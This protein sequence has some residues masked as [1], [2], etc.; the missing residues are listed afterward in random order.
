MVW[1]PSVEDVIKANKKVVRKS[2]HAHKMLRSANA[3]QSLIDSVKE[4]A[5]MGMT[6]QAAR[7]MK[8]IVALHAFDGGNH[9]TGYSIAILFLMQ[10]GV[11]VHFVSET[12]AYP[13]TQAIGSKNL[14][15]VQDWIER[16]MA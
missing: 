9:R 12:I 6:Y 15:E 3:I 14:R 10:N 16:Y 5:W 8:D 7:F 2:K 11:V 1:Y 13:F 4:S